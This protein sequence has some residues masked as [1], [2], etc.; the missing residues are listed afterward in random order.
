MK[1]IF[2]VPH[3]HLDPVWRRCFDRPAT[4]HGVTVRSYADVE[5]L[6]IDSWLKLAR[7][8]Y[9]YN[10]G[11]A[12]VWRKYL[13]RNP[14]KRAALRKEA[15]RGTLDLVYAGEVVPDSNMSTAEGLV[16]NFLVA[17]PL[18]RELADA[19]HPGLKLGWLEDSFGNSANYPQVLAGVGAE[20]ACATTYRVCPDP[21]WTGIDGTQILCYD[22]YPAVRRGGFEKHAPCPACSG[23]GCRVCSGTGMHLI[24]GFD[25]EA[26]RTALEE[27]LFVKGSWSVVF[28]LVE[29]ILPD[30]KLK[31]V[32]DEFNRRYRNKAVARFGNPSDI[33][34]RY[35]PQLRRIKAEWKKTEPTPELVP[36]MPGC[37]VSRIRCKQRTRASAYS[38]IAA[39]AALANA[40]WR[41]R[42]AK[43]PPEA[44]ER[45]WRNVC[46]NQFHDAI[47]GTHIDAAY[48][49]LMSMLDRAD[50]TATRHLPPAPESSRP[51]KFSAL[52]RFPG[53]AR[54]GKFEIEFDRT[55]LI[56]V[57]A[58]GRDVFGA[59]PLF[60]NLTRPYRIAELVLEPD[61]GD[62]W[63]QRIAPFPEIER[64]RGRIALGDYQTR[65]EKSARALRWHGRYNGGDPMV[66]QLRWTVTASLSPDGERIDFVTEVD[67]DTSSRRLRVLV[68]VRSRE[69]TATYEIPFGFI[70][71]KFDPAKLDYSQWRSHTMEFPALHWGRKS[72][73]RRSGVAILNKGLPCLRWL[74][75]RFDLSLLR[76][77]QWGFCVGEA[78]NYEFWGFEGQ[79]DTGHHRFEYALWPYYDGLSEH[80][81][82]TAGYAYN[83]PRPLELPFEL[84]GNVVTTAWKLAE[85]G[86][87]WILRLQETA[88]RGSTVSLRFDRPVILTPTD[89]LERP[90]APPRTA[91]RHRFE[92]HRHGIKTVQ[93]QFLPKTGN[94][95]RLKN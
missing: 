12:A 78:T 81:L 82:T 40:S 94:A 30:P 93:V 36:A 84:S 72:I 54:W 55:G 15:R 89:L 23:R 68:P 67:W 79:R 26:L 13:E 73:D 28:Y 85:D 75:G 42:R 65:V 56:S 24:P 47:T 43:R 62:A 35:R 33:Y 41:R 39:E 61:F 34:R 57:Q 45:A 9:P 19:D 8:G 91:S 64:E 90:V 2:V 49:E 52:S 86:S 7:T 80:D 21:V 88:G 10:D 32:M 38:L 50:R 77:P 63:G 1:E 16:R 5:E 71:R 59:I 14:E 66:K 58:K 60:S 95:S 48:D 74:P 87:G 83:L 69:D 70:D 17:Q 3:L 18:Y 92:I 51:A 76:S 46:F 44:L 27:A 37:M 6:C 22:H 11:Q 20:V 31:P 4:A 25:T 53:K 29:E